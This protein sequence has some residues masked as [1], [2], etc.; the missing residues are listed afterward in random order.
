MPAHPAPGYGILYPDGIKAIGDHIV[1][2]NQQMDVIA[3]SSREAANGLA[4]IN[5]A[6]NAMDQNTQKNGAM[7]EELLATAATLDSYCGMLR[8]ARSRFRTTGAAQGMFHTFAP[9]R[10]RRVA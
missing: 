7:V 4:E 3:V 9:P 6:V 8:D 5:S 2:I 10:P 1:Q